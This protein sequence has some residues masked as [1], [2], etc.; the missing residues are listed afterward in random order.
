MSNKRIFRNK[1]FIVDGQRYEA[2]LT[3][4]YEEFVELR[5][6]IRAGFGTQSYC[7]FQGLRN[8][9]YYYNHGHWNEV[10]S[11]TITP[12]LIAALIR[13]A[14]RNEWEPEASKSNKRI[15]LSHSEAKSIL[16]QYS[17]G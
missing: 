14:R 7:T 17:V 13:Y 5:V 11:T 8:F 4:V 6:T 10:Q 3:A 16:D 12:R 1:P 15:D 9:D 2:S